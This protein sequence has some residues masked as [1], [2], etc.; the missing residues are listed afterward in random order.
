MIGIAQLISAWYDKT[1]QFYVEE[2]SHKTCAKYWWRNVLYIHNLFAF[3]TMVRTPIYAM[4]Q[5]LLL[6]LKI[7]SARNVNYRFSVENLKYSFNYNIILASRTL[8]CVRE[9][10]YS[11]L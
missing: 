11:E 10:S 4:F 9:I 6:I 7:C 8:R 3:N 2:I 1:S 5:N